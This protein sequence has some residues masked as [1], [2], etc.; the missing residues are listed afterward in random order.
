MQSVIAF[1]KEHQILYNKLEQL[2]QS[3]GDR[4]YYLV[5]TANEILVATQS[6]F[7]QENEAFF[8]FTKTFEHLKLPVPKIL[9][10][11]ADK[12]IYLQTFAGSTCLL[13]EVVSKGFEPAVFNL[14]KQ[15]LKYLAQMQILGHSKINYNQCILATRFD[16]TYAYNDLV[17]CKTFYADAVGITYSAT[18]LENDFKLL[19]ERIGNIMPVYFMYR[20]FQGRNIMVHKNQLTFIDYQGGMAGPLAYDVASL[21]WQAKAAL[22]ADWKEDLLHY[23]INT[24]NILLPEPIDKQNFITEYN[25]IVLMRLLQVLGAYG[26]RGLL[27]GKKHFVESIPNAIN[28][29]AVLEKDIA[30]KELYPELHKFITQIITKK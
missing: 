19:A 16:A 1:L 13:D 23:Y 10:I 8:S 30:I 11:S 14:Y 4:L 12:K 20:D 21:L 26:K 24:I 15:A 6:N 29:L 2:P 7:V 25:Y 28:N 22:P 27:E 3:G 17:Y 18:A 9:A 5:H